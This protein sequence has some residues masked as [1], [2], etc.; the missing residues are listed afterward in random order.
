M[1]SSAVSSLLSSTTATVPT[2]SISDI[3]AASS[4]SSTAGIDVTS[5]VAA[6]IYADR[7]TE[8][9]WQAD[10]TTLTS[11]TTALTAIQT[12]TEAIATDMES[13]NTLTGPLAARTVSSSNSSY[14]TA[15]AATGT[16][17]GVHSVVV[18][19]VAS[20]AA[21][22]S[23]TES[24]PTTA[25]PTSSFTP[26][27]GES[28]TFQTGAATTG[29][30][31]ADLAI[32]INT[33][34]D[35]TTKAGLG[36]TASVVSDSTGS[37]L[38][39][40]SN[41]PGAAADF[42]VA[43]P[44]TSWSAPQMASGDTL[45]TNSF[46]FTSA[47]GTATVKTTTGETYSELAAAINAATVSTSYSSTAT[48]LTSTTQLTKGSVTTIQ[49]SSSGQT[50]SYTAAAGDTVATLNSAIAAA[51]TAGT[52]SANVTASVASGQE[53]ISEGST[54]QGITVSSTDSAVGAMGAV[55]STTKSLGLTATAT[56][57]ASGNTNLTITGSFTMNE[58]SSTSSDSAFSFTQAVQG[59]NASLTVDGVPIS[60]ATNTVT[61]AIPGVTLSLLGSD[62]G[63]QIDL[64]VGS[65]TTAV[66]TGINQ[67]VTDYNT[68][69]GLVNTQFTVDSTTN[70]EGVLSTD[71][72]MRSLQNMLEQSMSY[73]N[74]PTT[75][76]TT[77]STLS[78][79][80][81]TMAN[82]GTL[83]V[84]STTLSNALTNNPTD[85]QNFFEG[86][87]LN[88]FANSFYNSLNTYTEPST[89]AFSVDLTSISNENSDLT[90]QINNFETN[91]ITPQQTL[92]TADYTSAEVALQQLPQEMAELN[93]ELGFT[94]S[95]SS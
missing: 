82:D 29:D 65:D 81:I 45:G 14:L 38:A 8:R 92:L 36:V 83:S 42:S 87:A 43:E 41:D 47:A 76:T 15:T 11:Q 79:L 17:A 1:S 19:S 57:D 18:N 46:V 4:G 20:T 55:A 73:A 67:F 51:V 80:G 26:A 95:S 35:P 66:S 61:G 84:D 33:Y 60:S 25:L 68:A 31:L 2:Y 52:L 3:L 78:D 89:G 21:W 74:T 30:T 62:P 54:D 50:F 34:Q 40:V 69:I 13:L 5:A 28:V 93:S 85:V 16:A 90:T 56:T 6:A 70:A 23:G 32:A 22:Y 72:T 9:A 24:L 94:S 58:P 27:T 63:S 12:A 7:A 48:G 44:Y 49:D 64:T 53:V 59:A 91:Y 88:G 39:I 37:R 10:Q 75:G 77:V 86:T 71:P